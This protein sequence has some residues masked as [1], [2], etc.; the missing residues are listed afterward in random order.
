[1]V[2]VNSIIF[3]HR[4]AIFREFIKTKEHKWVPKMHDMSDI[5]LVSAQRAKAIYN[6][7]NTKAKLY[8]PD[9]SVAVD[10][11]ITNQS[12]RVSAFVSRGLCHATDWWRHDVCSRLLL[13]EPTR[14]NDLLKFYFWIKIY[15]FRTIPLSITRSLSPY[16]Q[17]WYM[18]YRFLDSFRAAGSGWNCSSAA[19]K[20]SKNL[21]DIYHCWVYSE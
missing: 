7:K 16:M 8:S 4:S 19:R 11:Q 21:Y 18:S 1:M 15:M 13:T 14:W 3:R 9:L 2:S 10:I 17:Q 12:N 20:L 6:Y 5:N